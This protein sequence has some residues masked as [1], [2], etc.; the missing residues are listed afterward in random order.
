MYMYHYNFIHFNEIN[1]VLII[2]HI[3]SCL[4]HR[5]VIMALYC[6]AFCNLLSS[7]ITSKISVDS[8][9]GS[10][11]ASSKRPWFDSSYFHLFPK[12]ASHQLSRKSTFCSFSALSSGTLWRMA[13]IR[14]WAMKCIR[15][16]WPGDSRS[17]QRNASC[18][19]KLSKKDHV[20]NISKRPTTIAILMFDIWRSQS[21]SK[22]KR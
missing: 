22:R 21:S 10:I 1:M 8:S 2:C 17:S 11:I 20:L 13:W 14:K 19:S 7:Q 18:T 9:H 5:S 6:C 3:S 4:F 15:R 16:W 12:S